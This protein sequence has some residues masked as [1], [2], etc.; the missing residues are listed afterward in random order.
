TMGDQI[1][2]WLVGEKPVDRL[3]RSVAGQLLHDF[4][5]RPESRS[6]TLRHASSDYADCIRFEP[7]QELLRKSSLP[8]PWSADHSDEVTT[9][10]LASLSKSLLNVSKF[11]FTTH[12]GDLRCRQSRP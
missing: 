12:E 3:S 2:P 11:K 10:L 1:S 8:C 5:E 9:S 6:F 4:R 7:T